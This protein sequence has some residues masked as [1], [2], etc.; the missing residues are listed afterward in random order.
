MMKQKKELVNLIKY[1]ID[2]MDKKIAK[3]NSKKVHLYDSL[4]KL[5]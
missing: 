1:D 4:N 3:L 2:Y 5:K